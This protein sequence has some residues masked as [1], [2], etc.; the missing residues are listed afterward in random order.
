MDLSTFTI[1]LFI[2]RATNYNKV[3]YRCLLDK[4]DFTEDNENFY[5]Q[6]FMS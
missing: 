2:T 5:S 6:P 1:S 4:F 3:V